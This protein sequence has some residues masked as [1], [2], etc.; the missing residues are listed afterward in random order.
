MSDFLTSLKF[1]SSYL[2]LA[3]TVC[4]VTAMVFG[5]VVVFKPKGNIVHKRLGYAYVVAMLI[6]NIT[7]FGIY[8]FGSL[9]LFHAFA[10]VSLIT[11]LAGV[12][13]AMRRTKGWFKKHYFFMSW[14]VV[15]LYCA[16]WAEV[17]VRFFD[18]RY[19]WWVVMGASM[20]TGFIGMLIINKTAKRLFVNDKT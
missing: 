3:H 19:F 2:G 6:M 17:G 5:L 12:I 18:M 16:F 10:L 13:P 1:F 9:S 8:N 7:G 15:G 14:S 4:A 11:L 20:L